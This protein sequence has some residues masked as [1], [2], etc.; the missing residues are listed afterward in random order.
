MAT[1]ILCKAVRYKNPKTGELSER[2]AV[3]NKEYDSPALFDYAS[4][5]GFVPAGSK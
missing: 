4:S 5:S 3:V 2:A 1:D